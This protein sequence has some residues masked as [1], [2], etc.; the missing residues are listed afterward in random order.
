MINELEHLSYKERSGVLHLFVQPGAGK[1]Q[2]E[3]YSYVEISD[4]EWRR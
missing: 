1:S 2:G 3:S 4:W